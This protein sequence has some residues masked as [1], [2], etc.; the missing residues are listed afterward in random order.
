[1]VTE[2]HEKGGMK[3]LGLI[4]IILLNISLGIT[5][6]FA[7]HIVRQSK[8]KWILFASS[9]GYTAFLGSGIIASA[10][11]SDAVKKAVV[12]I[13]SILC[14]IGAANLWVSFIF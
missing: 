7:P 2:L 3:H 6:I 9:L 12:I 1:M 8:A 11:V 10:D 5:S 13:G 4:S 14:G